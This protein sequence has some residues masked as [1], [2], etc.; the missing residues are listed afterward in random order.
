LVN[1]LFFKPMYCIFAILYSVL[2]PVKSHVLGFGSSVLGTVVGAFVFCRF[3]GETV[4]CRD[5]WCHSGGLCLLAAQLFEDL[6]YVDSFLAILS[7]VLYFLILVP[8]VAN[9]FAVEFL[10]S[11][12]CVVFVHSQIILGSVE[13][14]LYFTIVDQGPDSASGAAA[15][16]FF[17]ILH[18]A[19][20]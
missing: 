15:M 3:V 19:C 18:S 10:L 11:F 2:Y 8:F 6:S 4:C 16:T 12:C 5:V 20:I 14:E 7:M 17:M 1:A 13:C 9:P